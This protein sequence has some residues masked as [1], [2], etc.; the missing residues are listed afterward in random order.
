MTY[1]VALRKVLFSIVAFAAL[2][3]VAPTTAFSQTIS[4]TPVNVPGLCNSVSFHQI[5]G[6]GNYFIGRRLINTTTDGCSGSNWTLSLF[7]MDWSSHTLNRIRDVISL[8][9]ALT[10]Q[11]A[12]ITSA[13]DPTVMSFNGELWMSFE[14][15]DT[16][17]SSGGVSSCL[18]PISSTTFDVDTARMT[19]AVSA[20]QQTAFNDGYSASVP[21]L[22]QF[23]GTP[24]MYWSVSHLYKVQMAPCC[25]IRRPEERCLLRNPPDYADSG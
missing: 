5:P 11:N 3:L 21:K 15:V 4:T 25:L 14:C 20:I 7:Q 12:T 16:G 1:L 23:G 22:F 18:A 6:N 9:V 24:Y 8:P 13:Y 2:L 17:A 10:D 19:V